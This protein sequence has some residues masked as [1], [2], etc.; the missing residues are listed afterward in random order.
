M[1]YLEICQRY[2]FTLVIQNIYLIFLALYIFFTICTR[3]ALL[4]PL[5]ILIFKQRIGYGQLYFA[6]CHNQ[7]LQSSNNQITYFRIPRQPGLLVGT[8]PDFC[9][10]K[11]CQHDKIPQNFFW[12]VFAATT[13]TTTTKDLLFNDKKTHSHL[14]I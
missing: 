10:A 6:Q 4:R 8:D 9:P 11:D 7:L 3:A 13:T 12:N 1:K 2:S 5:F 14:F